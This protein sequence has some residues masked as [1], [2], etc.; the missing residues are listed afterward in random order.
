MSK[1]A[2]LNWS[3]LAKVFG[4]G[5]SLQHTCE[6]NIFKY[7][8]LGQPALLEPKVYVANNVIRAQGFDLHTL[9]LVNAAC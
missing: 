6:T 8:E 5:S 4:E 1:A 2:S 3:D 9:T 7:A